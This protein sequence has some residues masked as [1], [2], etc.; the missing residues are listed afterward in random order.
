[1]ENNV[2]YSDYKT[3]CTLLSSSE[4][5]AGGKPLVNQLGI[6]ELGQG[7]G[8]T[9]GKVLDET[10]KVLAEGFGM[11]TDLVKKSDRAYYLL[12]YMNGKIDLLTY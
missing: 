1:V 5:S 4:L 6:F 11:P 10:G 7:F 8:A 9:N 3:S 2:K 12:N